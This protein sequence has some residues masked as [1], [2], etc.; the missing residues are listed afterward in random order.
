MA[1]AFSPVPT[2]RWEWKS[3][4]GCRQLST[5]AE[6]QNISTIGMYI[7]SVY[8][9]MTTM[10]EPVVTRMFRNGGSWAVRIPASLVPPT[11]A[12]EIRATAEGTLEIRPHHEPETLDQLLA[13]WEQEGPPRD[14]IEKWPPRKPFPG[15]FPDLREDDTA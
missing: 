14:A 3:P 8:T 5:D 7:Q 2:A 4:S 15:R 1:E 13:K 10:T 6:V 9:T 12:V 11:Q